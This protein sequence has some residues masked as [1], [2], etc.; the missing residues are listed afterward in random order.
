VVDRQGIYS[1]QAWAEPDLSAAAEALTR[2]RKDADLGRRL[3]DAARARVAAQLSPEAWFE[4]LPERVRAAALA[5]K[6]A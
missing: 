3:G 2:L 1:G 6:T 5:A 4:T